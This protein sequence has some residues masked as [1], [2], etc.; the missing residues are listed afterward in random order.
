MCGDQAIFDLFG[1]IEFIKGN[2]KRE[3]IRSAGDRNY[4]RGVFDG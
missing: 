3:R 2:Q 4:D 1:S